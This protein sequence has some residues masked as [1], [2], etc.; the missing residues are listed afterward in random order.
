MN[1]DRIIALAYAKARFR[2][3]FEALLALDATLAN[4]VRA[5]RDP[6]LGQIRL[7]WW[8]DELELTPLPSITTDPT[9]S[10]IR[11]QIACHDVIQGLCVAMVNGWEILLGDWPPD[12]ARL[13]EFGK[14]RGGSLFTAAGV[15]SGIGITDA[16]R[17]SGVA[18]ALRDL[19]LHCSD[20]S[21]AA[22]ALELAEGEPPANRNLLPEMR[23]FFILARFAETDVKGDPQKRPEIGSP[24][25]ILQALG[26]VFLRR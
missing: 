17:T 19:S 14:L 20:T 16:L 11:A 18:W 8:R 25:R 3:P 5:A 4:A 23:P 24:H 15:V 9:L 21:V 10:A 1:H 13:A 2:R 7:A 22:R 12:D 6:V 26:I